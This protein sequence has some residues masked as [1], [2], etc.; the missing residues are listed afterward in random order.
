MTHS[1]QPCETCDRSAGAG[2]CEPCRPAIV[3]ENGT[4]EHALRC[5]PVAFEAADYRKGFEHGRIAG[6]IAAEQICRGM[7]AETAATTGAIAVRMCLTAIMWLRTEVSPNDELGDIVRAL[8]LA[9]DRIE[10]GDYARR[11]DV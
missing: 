1:R 3:T 10:Q 5:W 7:L 4:R 6:I 9:I 2:W 8:R 11:G